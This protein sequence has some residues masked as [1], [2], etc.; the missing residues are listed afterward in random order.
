LIWGSL[1]ELDG[2]CL[3][4]SV[5]AGIGPYQVGALP[6]ACILECLWAVDGELLVTVD[7]EEMAVGTVCHSLI[8]WIWVDTMG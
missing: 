7:T 6:E 4:D 2:E 5:V 8:Q 1:V 3:P